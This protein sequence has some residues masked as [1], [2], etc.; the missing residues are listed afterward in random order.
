[1]VQGNAEGPRHS[2]RRRPGAERLLEAAS[3]LFYKEGIGAV[4]VDTVSESAAVS[5]RTLYNR[6]GGKDALVAEY[7][8][9][10][11]ERWRAH[12][13]DA[14][15]GL[16]EAAD[17]LL[18][19]FESYGEWLVGDEFR[20]CAFANAVAEIP[21]SDHPACVVARRHKEGVREYLA[22]AARDAGFDEPDT[23]AERL[24]ILLEGATA[25]AAMRRN[26]EPLD[27]ARSVALEL[28][29]TRSR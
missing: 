7:L 4:G 8:R 17:K 6:F 28:M 9:R 20:G 5:K 26:A 15:E 1:M 10:R 2:T 21:D 22:A 18:A 19:V 14:T 16:D 12:L 11:D 27:V 3:E 25:T 24:L 23:L 29:D 13:R